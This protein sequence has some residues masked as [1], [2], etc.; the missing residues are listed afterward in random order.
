MTLRP[1]TA[2]MPGVDPA[3]GDDRGLLRWP[4]GT[5]RGAGFADAARGATAGSKRQGQARQ[6]TRGRGRQ[7]TRGKTGRR[8]PRPRPA[9]TRLPTI[10][11]SISPTAPTSADASARR[12]RSR[13]CAPTRSSDV[14]AMTLLGELYANGFGTNRDDS[15]AALWYKA[16]ADRGDREAMFALAMFRITGRG[17]RPTAARAPSCSPPPPSSARPPRLQSRPALSRGPDL[18]AGHPSARP[19]CFARPP[20]PAIPK[21][22]TRWRRSTRRAA[23]S[24]RTSPRPRGCCKRRRSPTTSTPR[25]NMPSRCSMAPACRRTKMRR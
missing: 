2:M 20:T 12:C 9:S 14:H 22:S 5:R 23:A 13:P 21:P 18:S 7:E 19:N 24:R 3:P 15:K 6:Q 25:S 16:A 1:E 17:G 11:M 8:R 4:R 10:P